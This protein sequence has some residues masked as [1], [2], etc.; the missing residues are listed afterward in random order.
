MGS[1]GG[2]ERIKLGLSPVSVSFDLALIPAFCSRRCK[3]GYAE[4]WWVAALRPGFGEIRLA[5][6]HTCL[7]SS[8][9]VF[10]IKRSSVP[11]TRS[12]GLAI[13]WLSTTVIVDCQGVP[14]LAGLWHGVQFESRMKNPRRAPP[15]PTTQTICLFMT[16]SR[17]GGA[18]GNTLPR[19]ARLDED[20]RGPALPPPYEPP[21][22]SEPVER[23]Y[24]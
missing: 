20:R 15:L 16:I 11:W 14:I 22:G 13:L 21:C 8:E 7:G 9:S 17:M 19:Q 23:R 24:E 3:A 2:G 18:P 1:A 4:P 10:R 12:F 5:I 6:A